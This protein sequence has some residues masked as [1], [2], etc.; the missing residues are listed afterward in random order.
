MRERRPTCLT[1]LLA[2]VP[3]AVVA[4]AP[5]GWLGIRVDFRAEGASP[6]ARLTA[7][8]I[9]EVMP[10]SPAARAGLRVGD[11]LE[12]VDG[13]SVAGARA[14]SLAPALEKRVG[15]AVRLYL[16]HRDGEPYAVVL[17]AAE[18]PR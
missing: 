13:L 18:N 3:L 11:H 2:L 15:E 12:A 14:H 10:G 4:E 1:L 8:T 17:V 7:A 9:L 5:R 16:V 6:D